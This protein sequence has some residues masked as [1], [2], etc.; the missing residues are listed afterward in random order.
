[1]LT[2]I[3]ADVTDAAD[4]EGQCLKAEVEILRTTAKRNAAMLAKLEQ[5]S[6]TALVAGVASNSPQPS[7][8]CS[9]EIAREVCL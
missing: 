7:S 8:L 5:Q 9:P 1:M 3:T 2:S 4:S 6:Q